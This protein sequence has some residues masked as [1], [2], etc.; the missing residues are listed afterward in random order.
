MGTPPN[1][2][3]QSRPIICGHVAVS[4]TP[5]L[6][7]RGIDMDLP[8]SDTWMDRDNWTVTWQVTGQ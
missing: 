2:T 6:M 1:D 7:T 8:T 4:W 3:W 5:P